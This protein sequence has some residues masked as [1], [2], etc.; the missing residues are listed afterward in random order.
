MYNT[1]YD[2]PFRNWKKIEIRGIKKQG[3]IFVRMWCWNIFFKVKYT[4]KNRRKQRRDK[5]K[6]LNKQ[7]KKCIYNR[8][9]NKNFTEK[10]VK[11]S[12][13][14]ILLLNTI[15]SNCLFINSYQVLQCPEGQPDKRWNIFA[16]LKEAHV[17]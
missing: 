10:L 11:R 13:I 15:Q 16:G 12:K 2:F 17:V 1:T 9:P 14:R 3:Y 5:N 4:F 8:Q 6:G 7:S